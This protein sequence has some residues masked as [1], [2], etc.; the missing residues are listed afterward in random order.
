MNT[1]LQELTIV[2]ERGPRS[3]P[4]AAGFGPAQPASWDLEPE[5]QTLPLSHYLWV[6]RRH[7]WKILSFIGVSAIATLIVSA[8]L[9]PMY[10]ATV[11]VDVDRKVPTAVVG[12]DSTQTGLN[13]ADQFLATQIKLIQSDA[14]L[15]PVADQYHLRDLERKA[16]AGSD[17]GL[18]IDAPVLLK[19]L[20]V[21]RPVNTYLLLISYRS[22]D[23][24]LAAD[25]ANAIARSFVEHTYDIRFRSSASLSTFM[26]KQLE[27]LR[28]KMERSDTALA[29]FEKELNVI[30]PEE[31]TNI[32]SARLLQLNTDYT[33]AETE[34]V[35]KEA[36]YKSVSTGSLESAQ[37]STQGDALKTIAERLEQAQEKFAEVKTHYGP[38]HPEFHKA[39]TQLDQ[40][41]AQFDATRGSVMR[42]VEVEFREGVNR[43]EML[44]KAVTET[45]AEFDRLNAR[46]FEYESLKHEAEADKKLYEELIT[47]IRE[48][49]INAGF[50]S[51]TV[52][53]ADNA[54][55]GLSPVF[56]NV[57]LNVGLALLFAAI[58]AVGAAVLS[59]TLDNT[60][61]NTE[62]VARIVKA[63]VIGGLPQVK[64]WKSRPA[65]VAAGGAA[66]TPV[67]LRHPDDDRLLA[68]FGEAVRTLRNSILLSS[69]DR[70]IKS[71]MVTSATPGEGKS[72]VCVHLAMAH[73][74][75]NHRT[76][77][78]DCD[79]RRPSVHRRLGLTSETGLSAVL[80]H[81]LAWRDCVMQAPGVPN[82]D[83]LP[84]GPTSRRASDLIGRAL[85]QILEE[86]AGDYDLVMVDSPPALGFPEPL[87]MATAVDGVA[88]IAL[89]GQT[90]RKALASVV[91]MLQ[92]LRANVVGVALNEVTKDI[93]DSYYYHGYYGKYAR[94]YNH[95]TETA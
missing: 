5:E 31:K 70:Q 86:A 18:L 78:I 53:I 32:L 43:E 55:P 26:E 89:A 57:P 63:E 10:E 93:G 24:R 27:E 12:Q 33:N 71:L 38:N 11:T 40:V 16:R 75:Q 41:Q 77:L 92:R 46:S 9:T 81:G 52:R 50:Q 84:A 88:L 44:K 58:L 95:K 83:V 22:P 62:Q 23:R 91:S 8:R 64:S 73:A 59:D 79:L 14:V 47:K 69:F 20:K 37:A 80:L 28:A 94:Y 67:L 51:N 61:R 90:D 82:L 7:R 60:I 2:E 3:L 34:R 19:Q 68:G 66:S 4:V 74:Q 56:P 72:T 48:A 76:L 25:V 36:A 35:K 85:P 1:S 30:N 39:Q 15:R 6:L 65:L 49:E 45:K 42:R 29:Q 17:Q 87:Q 13:D 54:R 21:T